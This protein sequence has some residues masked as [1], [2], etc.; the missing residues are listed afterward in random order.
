MTD[1][2]GIPSGVHGDTGLG[3]AQYLRELPPARVL[4]RFSGTVLSERRIVSS[5]EIDRIAREFV[6]GEGL[7]DAFKGL[8]DESRR[9][10]ALAYLWLP[11]GLPAAEAAGCGSQ[12]IES[13]LVYAVRDKDNNLFLSWVRG[14][15]SG[16]RFSDSGSYSQYQ[17]PRRKNP[18]AMGRTASCSQRFRPCDTTHCAGQSSGNQKR[19]ALESINGYDSQAASLRKK[20]LRA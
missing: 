4:E 14:I 1:P 20:Q 10:C 6:G 19:P 3:F 17:L 13:F 2:I 15:S 12:V 7:N 18:A 8:D 16:T 11:E 5:S 9:V